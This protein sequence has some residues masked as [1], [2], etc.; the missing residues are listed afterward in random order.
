MKGLLSR[1]DMNPHDREYYRREIRKGSPRYALAMVFWFVCAVN[2]LIFVALTY[3][4]LLF[5]L[6]LPFM[7]GVLTGGVALYLQRTADRS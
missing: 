6:P 2:A 4:G 5:L 7:T 1:E 3:S